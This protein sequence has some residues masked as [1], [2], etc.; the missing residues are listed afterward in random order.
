MDVAAEMDGNTEFTMYVDAAF[1]RETRVVAIF[2]P[3]AIFGI[4]L[5]SADA[6]VAGTRLATKCI[7][8]T[9]R[10]VHGNVVVESDTR[11]H[12]DC[13]TLLPIEFTL[14]PR[15]DGTVFGNVAEY[16]AWLDMLEDRAVC[17]ATG[18]LL[19]CDINSYIGQFTPDSVVAFDGALFTAIAACHAGKASVRHVR[20]CATPE[21]V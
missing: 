5:P 19:Y 4:V 16:Q 6:I 20:Q 10:H 21:Y 13:R 17:I 3:N 1:G 18:M 2:A 12:V 15:R 11:R 14:R 7:V 8:L 9:R